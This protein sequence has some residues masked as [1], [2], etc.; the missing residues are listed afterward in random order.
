MF[1]LYLSIVVVLG[2]IVSA[3]DDYAPQYCYRDTDCGPYQRCRQGYCQQ[4]SGSSCATVYCPRGFTC[5]NGQCVR[6]SGSHQ[7]DRYRPCKHGQVCKNGYCVD[8]SHRRCSTYNPCPIGKVCR[9]GYCVRRGGGGG[10]V[11]YTDRDCPRTQNCVSG[12]C[13]YYYI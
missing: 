5:I 4:G 8:D 13:Q 9:R 3:Q 1:V 2:S 7:C 6:R 12:R 10:R 11:C